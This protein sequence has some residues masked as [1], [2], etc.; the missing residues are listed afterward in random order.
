MNPVIETERTGTRAAGVAMVASTIISIITVALDVGP[1]GRSKAELLA[2][3]AAVSGRHQFVHIVAMCCLLGFAFGVTTL[4]QRAGTR[5]WPVLAGLI[6]YLAGCGAMMGAV[7]MDGFISVDLALK[8]ADGTA[9]DIATG[10]GLVQF[11]N[12]LLQNLAN[13]AWMMQAV[14]V[15]LIS[16]ALVRDH[17]RRRVLGTIGLATGSLPAIAIVATY[18]HMDLT[19]VVGIMVAQ[20]AWHVCVGVLLLRGDAA[21]AGSA[22]MAPA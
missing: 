13:I 8:F 20:A 1:S 14:G 10:Y 11:T 15:L 12:V 18:P 4:A 2:G 21:N 22:A 5:R 16:I 19:L 17:G 6:C 3:M 7:L 9:E